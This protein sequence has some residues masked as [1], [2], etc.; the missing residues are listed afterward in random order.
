MNKFTK[1]IL[2]ESIV[3]MIILFACSKE[4]NEYGDIH[5]KLEIC[6]IPVPDVHARIDSVIVDTIPEIIQLV[7]LNSQWWTALVLVE[8]KSTHINNQ[9]WNNGNPFTTIQ[10]IDSNI[11]R[12]MIAKTQNFYWRW[13]IRFT[14]DHNEYDS[15]TGNK[16]IMHVVSNQV[17]TDGATSN[18]VLMSG[19]SGVAYISSLF[20]TDINDGFVFANMLNSQRDLASTLTHETG[21]MIGLYHKS[22]YDANGVKT[23]EYRP[24]CTMGN[25]LSPYYWGWITGPTNYGVTI[26]Q[27][28]TLVLGENLGCKFYVAY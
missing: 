8:Y 5:P 12:R 4:E 25:S 16:D 27:N 10:V 19:G 7:D 21:H 26:I 1:I 6:N 3:L 14:M 11:C 17:R 15:F 9:Y 13:R 24:N 28:D 20:Y 22:V 2:I 18:N 23:N